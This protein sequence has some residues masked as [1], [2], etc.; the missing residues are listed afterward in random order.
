MHF[1]VFVRFRSYP[2]CFSVFQ[3]WNMWNSITLLSSKNESTIIFRLILIWRC[4]NIFIYSLKI[5]FTSTIHIW[6]FYLLV[7]LIE[8]LHLP[9]S[10]KKTMRFPR[11]QTLE[12]WWICISRYTINDN[13]TYIFLLRHDIYWKSETF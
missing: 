9:I 2:F 4:T 7:L 10:W 5:S 1:D 12:G 11:I 8:I 3:A 6:L 13:G